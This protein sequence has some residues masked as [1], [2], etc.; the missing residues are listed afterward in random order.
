MIQSKNKFL[1]PLYIRKCKITYLERSAILHRAG[2]HGQLPLIF[3]SMTLHLH[4]T[5][6]CAEY[7]DE[8]WMDGGKDEQ[9]SGWSP[10]RYSE[11]ERRD[12]KVDT[13]DGCW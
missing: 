12:K 11:R 3:E 6:R 2:C 7:M 1:P 8:Q 13:H 5:H 10:V 4:I 9:R